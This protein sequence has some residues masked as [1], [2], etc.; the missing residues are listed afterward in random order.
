[1][2]I[3]LLIPLVFSALIISCENNSSKETDTTKS[4]DSIT[5]DTAKISETSVLDTTGM[6]VKNNIRLIPLKGSVEFQDAILEERLPEQNAKLKSG[7]VIFEYEVKNYD[8]K[9]QTPSG[10]CHDCSNSK[11]GQH[12]HLILNNEPYIAIYEPIYKTTLKEGHYVALSFLSR[13]YHESIKQFEAFDLR[14][15]S[16]GNVKAKEI[17]L[18]Q[19][20]LFYSRPK[21]EYTGEGAK[22]V[23]LDFYL[24]NT[25]LSNSGNK[26]RATI[27]GNEFVIEKWQPFMIQGLPMGENTVKIEL[28]DKDGKLLSSPF[29]TIERKIMLK[30][31]AM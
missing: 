25:D 21:G 26:V 30:E 6:M 20:M 9:K 11:D 19:P 14:Q 13:S 4:K 15:F 16:V 22:N 31:Q 2:Q 17:D 5:K 24:V 12:I 23:L 8:L 27:N 29:N 28:I 7:E 1:M 3:R 10:P 18:S